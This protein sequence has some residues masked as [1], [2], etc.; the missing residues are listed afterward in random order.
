[1]FGCQSKPTFLYGENRNVPNLP[2]QNESG[3]S[4]MRTK[5]IS[6][7][8][9]LLAATM[10]SAGCG[11]EPE[12]LQ[13]LTQAVNTIS[14][15]QS[16]ASQEQDPF[17][18]ANSV[19]EAPYPDRVDP[20]SF[21]AGAPVSDQEGTTI[22]TVAQV[23]VLG[24]ANVDEPR[25]FLRAKEITKSLGVGDVTDGIEVVA[26]KPPAVELRMGS[27]TWTATMFDNS[28]IQN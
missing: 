15:Q 19:F 10:F 16:L 12:T 6:S 21:P 18:Q 28:S 22:T 27:L 26:I 9:V 13:S 11:V 2:I 24:F 7:F 25:V 4:R 17:G 20:F 3:E 23:R 8:S 5:S 14:A 1:M